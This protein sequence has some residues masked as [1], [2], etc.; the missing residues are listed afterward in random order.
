MEDLDM[1][2]MHYSFPLVAA[3]LTLV[4]GLVLLTHK[5]KVKDFIAFGLIIA[6]LAA[7]WLI[8]HPR[9]TPLMD[10]AKAVQAMVGAGK[11]VLLEFQSP[12]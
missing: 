9:Q 10:D 6:G 12:Y 7:S 1:Q 4:A 11:P 2:L 3:G 5:P 8:L